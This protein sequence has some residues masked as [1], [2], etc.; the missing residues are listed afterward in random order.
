L[1]GANEISSKYHSIKNQIIP[2]S[3][4][5][6]KYLEELPIENVEKLVYGDSGVCP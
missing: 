1:S 4:K 3:K 6:G 5:A 2:V